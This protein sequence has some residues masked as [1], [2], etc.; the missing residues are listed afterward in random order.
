MIFHVYAL[1]SK[2]YDKIYIGYTSNLQARI[3][4]HNVLATKGFTAK[5]R[6]WILIHT[7]SFQSKILAMKREKELKSAD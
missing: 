1:Y 6:P 7:E 2:A 4:S 5:F 3:N